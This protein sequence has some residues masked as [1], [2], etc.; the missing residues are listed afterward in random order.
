MPG[1]SGGV[2]ACGIR[3]PLRRHDSTPKEK[4]QA[5][6]RGCPAPPPRLPAFSNGRRG[7]KVALCGPLC[8]PEAFS[9]ALYLGFTCST[10][11]ASNGEG[12]APGA[13]GRQ[14]AART[15]ANSVGPLHVCAK[16]AAQVL[17]F[18]AG[19]STRHGG[20]DA[21]GRSGPLYVPRG[22]PPGS[23]RPLLASDSHNLLSYQASLRL[24]TGLLA[25]RRA[26]PAFSL[27]SG[28]R[29][30]P[31]MLYSHADDGA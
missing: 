27:F 11:R 6:S 16:E 1:S 12:A 23:P 24:C 15:Q 20:R 26:R 13:Q 25:L 5:A 28:Y 17:G 3:S 30:T 31:R 18:S 7:E 14:A 19:A 9:A 29:H 22:A 8:M 2:C 21:A 10:A 4:P